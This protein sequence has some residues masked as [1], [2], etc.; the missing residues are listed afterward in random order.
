VGFALLT[1]LADSS[2][3]SW[4]WPAV[5]LVGPYELLMMIVRSA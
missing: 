5:A 3:A 4:L 2:V 1:H